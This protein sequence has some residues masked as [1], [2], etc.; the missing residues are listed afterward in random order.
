MHPN[1]VR[2]ITDELIE[3][4]TI[5]IIIIIIIYLPKVKQHRPN[6]NPIEVH[7]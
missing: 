2:F 4:K 3:K 5:L 1:Y 6:S 7:E